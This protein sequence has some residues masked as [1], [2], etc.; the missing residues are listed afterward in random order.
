LPLL[1]ALVGNGAGHGN[2]NGNGN[3][4][5]RGGPI[6]EFPIMTEELGYPPAPAAGGGGGLVSSGLATPGRAGTPGPV[7]MKALQD[8]LG[9]KI[10]AGDPAGFIGALNQ[11]FQLSSVEGTVVSTWTPRSYVVQSDLSGGITGAQAS[12]YTM[13]KTLLDQTLP[14]IDGLYP[15]DPSS[16][17]EDVAAIKD[18][19]NSQLTNLTA[20]IGYLGGPRVMRVNQYFQRLL[21]VTLRLTYNNGEVTLAIDK[22]KPPRRSPLL[23]VF[24]NWG[25]EAKDGPHDYWKNPDYVLGSLGDLRDQLGLSQFTPPVYINTIPDEQD[26]TNFRIVVDYV[27]SLLSVWRS[28]IGFFAERS[29]KFLGTEL[30]YISRQL[31]VVSETVSE[32]RFVLDSV[33]VGAAQRQT[34]QIVFSKLS[35][36][37][38]QHLAPIYLEDLLQWM[39][40]FVG[41]EA[42]DVIQNAGKLGIGEDFC[43]MIREL[44]H[45]AYGLYL[46][47]QEQ[48]AN[49]GLRTVRVQQS[50]HKLVDQLG[51]LYRKSRPVGR[52]YL[53]PRGSI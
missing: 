50:L 20:E 14:L 47:A 17:I 27:N 52:D 19:V 45:Q 42:Q 44:Y 28:N 31:G 25:N 8:V 38:I 18:V 53:P 48:Q 5:F 4:G 36:P 26:T 9:W 22:D 37:K 12:I 15:L 2:G 16:N 11:S 10:K 46:Y 51:Q 24:K 34:E 6:P 43:K 39:Q 33:F 29:S 7:V 23:K 35:D 32:V 3:A 49:R 30:V 1:P 40:D 21:G 13:A 41:P